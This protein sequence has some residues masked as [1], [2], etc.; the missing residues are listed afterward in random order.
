MF[1]GIYVLLN[2][3]RGLI[4]L[5]KFKVMYNFYLLVKIMIINILCGDIGIFCVVGGYINWWGFFGGY[6]SKNDYRYKYLCV[7]M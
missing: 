5:I 1:Y 4:L 2:L 7:L 6:F 3:K